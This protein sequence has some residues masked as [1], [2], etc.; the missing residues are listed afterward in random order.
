MSDEPKFA[1][2]MRS[3]LAH[4]EQALFLAESYAPRE[5]GVI[6]LE[7]AKELEE[8][9]SLPFIFICY[10]DRKLHCQPRNV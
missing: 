9:G 2:F 8:Q 1:L 3:D 6:V 5:T 10:L 7:F 4:W